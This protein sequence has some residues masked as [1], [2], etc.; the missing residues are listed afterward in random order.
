MYKV[1]LIDDEDIIVEGLTRAVSWEDYDCQVV[2]TASDGIQGADVIREHQPDIIITDISMP[3]QN[4]LN[5]I[6]GLKSEYPQMQITVLT[7]FRDFSYAQQAI[8]LGVTRYLLKPS[9][10]NEIQEAIQAMIERLKANQPEAAPQEE[11]PKEDS[12]NSFIVKNA[13]KY[14]EE[15]YKEKLTLSEV[16]EKVYVSQWHLSKLLN[17]HTG[18]SFSEILNKIRIKQAKK[19][20]RDPSLR[21]TEIAEQVGFYDVAHF[22]RVFKKTEGISANEYRNTLTPV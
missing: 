3:N 6:A 22:A 11:P 21:I 10:W 15:H 20:L 19:L 7:G 13:L 14:L 5:M 1:V 9:K 16:A 2:A 17:K 4:G 8:K 12:S 18:Q